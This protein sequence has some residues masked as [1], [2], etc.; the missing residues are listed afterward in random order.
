MIKQEVEVA[1][2]YFKREKLEAKRKIGAPK[3]VVKQR[4]KQEEAIKIE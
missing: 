2:Q 4:Q 3:R 1:K